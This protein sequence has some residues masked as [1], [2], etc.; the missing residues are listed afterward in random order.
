MNVAALLPGVLCTDPVGPTQALR[1]EKLPQPHIPQD[2]LL[3]A[4]LPADS[5]D[6]SDGD[7]EPVVGLEIWPR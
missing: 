7:Q 5:P 2:H 6:V 3:G 4:V 1:N